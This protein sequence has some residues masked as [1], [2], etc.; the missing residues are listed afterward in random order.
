M[1]VEE[2]VVSCSRGGAR[3]QVQSPLSGGKGMRFGGARRGDAARDGVRLRN[4]L[5]TSTMS[6]AWARDI[7]VPPLRTRG[8]CL[9]WRVASCPDEVLA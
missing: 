2:S 9:R 5:K 6:K 1:Q 4:R 3:R 7:T 8:G